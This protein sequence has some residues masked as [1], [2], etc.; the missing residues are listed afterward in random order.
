L[1]PGWPTDSVGAEAEAQTERLRGFCRMTKAR[2]NFSTTSEVGKTTGL[3]IGPGIETSRDPSSITVSDGNPGF[4]AMKTS[5]KKK[6][7]E[8]T[9]RNLLEAARVVFSK[10]GYLETTVADIVDEA[11]V[12]RGT[13]YLYFD[14]RDDI[15][16]KLIREVVEEFFVVSIP[17]SRGSLRERIERAHRGYLENF[18]THRALIR[19]HLQAVAVNASVRAFH[20]ELRRKFIERIHIH[21]KRTVAL[22]ISPPLNPQVTAYALGLMVES[23]AYSWLAEG[24]EP[25]DEPLQ[26]DSVLR[27]L[28]DLWC[29]AA[30]LEG[31]TES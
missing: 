8:E 12:S 6:A 25:W 28:T 17:G 16:E 5:K 18:S 14:N 19:S 22:G 3:S 10:K 7:A 20:N 15:F 24:F 21:L 4:S 26:M 31:K 9:E 2:K 23:I 13:F 30:Y 11:N 29:R 27:E 1:P